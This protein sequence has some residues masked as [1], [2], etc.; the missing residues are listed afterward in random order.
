MKQTVAGPSDSHKISTLTDSLVRILKNCGYVVERD[1]DVGYGIYGGTAKAEI[2]AYNSKRFPEGLIVKPYWQSVSGS[3]DQ[4]FPYMVLTARETY[5]LPSVIVYAGGGY[6]EGAIEWLR[7]EV[8]E[9]L[10]AVLHVD[11]FAEWALRN[12]RT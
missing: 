1:V 11:E 3:A 9:Q 10:V 2:V 5:E 8:D 6:Q 7:R 12:K 4:K